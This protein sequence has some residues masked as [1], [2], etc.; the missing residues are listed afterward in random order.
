MESQIERREAL[1]E[2]EREAIALQGAVEPLRHI[3]DPGFV[4]VAPPLRQTTKKEK[5]MKE[6]TEFAQEVHKLTKE[7]GWWDGPRDGGQD[8]AAMHGYLSHVLEMR[9][10]G[11]PVRISRADLDNLAT[12]AT[13]WSSVTGDKAHVATILALIHSEVSEAF[14]AA[15]SDIDKPSEKIPGFSELAFELA[16]IA[17]RVFD[18][19]ASRGID[20]GGAIAAKHEYNKGRS[21]KHGGK[22]F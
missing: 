5:S 13:S 20:I 21:H 8:I 3:F 17:L 1:L 6:V 14:Q 19:A 9:R 7:K 2:I 10:K 16:G 15:K 12:V 22:R 18:F 4:P 11:V